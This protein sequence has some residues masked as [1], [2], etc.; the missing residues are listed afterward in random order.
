MGFVEGVGDLRAVLEHVVQGQR[1]LDEALFERF[2]FQ[3]LHND[4]IDSILVADIM[5]NADIG[6][7]Q[8]GYG[9]GF[10]FEALSGLGV[11]GQVVG[12]DLDC[13]LAVEA[14]VAGTVNFSHATGAERR[15]D[16][17]RA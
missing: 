8:A 6:M 12:Q 15:D 7:I 2:A 17:V 11:R 3:A 5:E 4:E 1:P 16:F 14:G 13:D 10:A 9:F